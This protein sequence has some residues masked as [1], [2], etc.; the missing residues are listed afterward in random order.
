MSNNRNRYVFETTLEGFINLA[1]PSGKYNNCAFSF[2]LPQAVM[3]EAE[4]DRE[5]LLKWA[6]SKVDGR[7]NVNM[8]KWD[9]TGLVKY[10]FDGET[11]RARPVVIDSN[12]DVVEMDVLKAIRG[13]TKVRLIVQQ[14]PYTKPSIGTSVKVLGMQIIELATGMGAVD[15]GNLSVAD[16]AE[17]FGTADGFNQSEPSVREAVAP[18][19]SGSSYDF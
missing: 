18:V 15:S 7:A 6:K 3:D 12:G 8:A 9:E 14:F 5:E 17:I 1:E 16:V 11:N 13:G 10:S 19:A 4:A 2:K